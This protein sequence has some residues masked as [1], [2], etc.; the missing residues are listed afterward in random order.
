[1][2]YA[3]YVALYR[4]LPSCTRMYQLPAGM[5]PLSLPVWR[6]QVRKTLSARIFRKENNNSTKQHPSPSS[7]VANGL[8]GQAKSSA[9]LTGH[10][11][12]SIPNPINTNLFRPRNK[13][14]GPQHIAGYPRNGKLITV[15]LGQN[16]GQAERHRL[17]DR[18]V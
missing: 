12:T 14:G 4:H 17:S 5:S 18:I 3:R 10:T 7:P 6:G 13:T 8:K 15:R 9:L 1:M 2:D 16:H 11:V